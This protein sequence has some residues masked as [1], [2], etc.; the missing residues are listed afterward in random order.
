MGRHWLGALAA[1]LL[2]A[3]V[4]FAI[5]GWGPLT[6]PTNVGWMLAGPIGPDPVQHWLGWTYFRQS[7]WTLPPG[8]N[9][10]YGI[11][12]ATAIYFADAIPLL[13]LPLK[14]L[15]GLVDI[16]QYAGP[17]LLA[18]GV[19]QALAGWG[20]MGLA[21]RNPLARA[22]G[23][24]LLALQPMLMNRM[25]GHIALSGQWTLLLA[26]LLAFTPPEATRRRG[27]LWGLL[28]AVTS[29]VHSYIFAMAAPVWAADWLGRA[30]RRLATPRALALEA[31]AVPLVVAAAL[32]AGGFFL[33]RGGHGGGVGSDFGR[34]GT[35][36]FE[37]LAWF[38]GG[39]WSALLPD[40]PNAENW[41][42]GSSYLGL[43][44][45]GLLLAGA[46]AWARHPV[47]LPRRL[48]PLL[49]MM[50]L[51]LAF[52]ITHRVTVLG[53][54]WEVFA[55]PDWM[56][57]IGNTLR[58]SERMAWPL[59]YGML[60][61]A[62]IACARAWGGRRTGYLLLAL[63]ALQWVDVSKGIRFR[64][65]LI[66]GAPHGIPERLFDPFWPEAARHYQR[67]RA[68]PAG[69]M[70]EGWESIARLA[71]RNGLPTDSVY[72]ARLDDTAAAALTA[73][74]REELRTGRY[75][76]G[77]LYVLRDAPSREVA[78]A[79]HDPARD[80]VIEADGYVVLAPGWRAR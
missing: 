5:F 78:R 37:L 2:G 13:A 24:G 79:S 42:H 36:N 38:D 66:A 3:L 33:L 22:C 4:P 23:A 7:P 6:D 50:L 62:A 20:L 44:G 43:G 63:L 14:A 73:R 75:E 47:A 11:E 35:W 12:L 52:A 18:C 9:P 26:L 65:S 41:E 15:S 32:W 49:G 8:A 60:V 71:A 77:T 34:Y 70:G 27:L 64:A 25:P 74:V 16:P 57:A 55:A 56:I 31:L 28:L 58:N 46:I 19:L 45:L 69:N 29:I 30:W 51:L 1:A 68:T 80:A 17:W 40:L 54:S 53:R 10:D 59:A 72:M 61:G 39:L 76:P 21:T 48:W 67:I